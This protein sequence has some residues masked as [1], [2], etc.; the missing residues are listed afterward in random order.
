[1]IKNGSLRDQLTKYNIYDILV[2]WN[3]NLQDISD[4]CLYEVITER[5]ISDCS[6]RRSCSECLAMLMN[7]IVPSQ[8]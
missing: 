5:Y 4:V 6:D 7:E 2:K 1:M 8:I 3:D